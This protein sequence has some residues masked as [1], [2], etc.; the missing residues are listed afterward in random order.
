[1]SSDQAY[2]MVISPI[3]FKVVFKSEGV[4]GAL[5]LQVFAPHAPPRNPSVSAMQHEICITVHVLKHSK[6]YAQ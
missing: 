2:N 5:A 4:K 6:V 1:M 3:I